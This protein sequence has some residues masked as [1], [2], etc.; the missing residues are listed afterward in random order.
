MVAVSLDPVQAVHT[1]AG[2][3][4]AADGARSHITEM[5][6]GGVGAR[7][8]MK[9]I[10]KRGGGGLRASLALPWSRETTSSRAIRAILHTLLLS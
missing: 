9:E 5:I 1:S 10:T 6:L 7:S 3:R 4:T 8:H 2:C